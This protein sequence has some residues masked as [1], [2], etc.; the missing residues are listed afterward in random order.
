MQVIMTQLWSHAYV[1]RLRSC[2]TF[3][4]QEVMLLVGRYRIRCALLAISTPTLISFSSNPFNALV[5]EWVA[6]FS[7]VVCICQMFE[8]MD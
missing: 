4:K 8:A 2:V 5:D 1:F 7:V 6:L 3:S